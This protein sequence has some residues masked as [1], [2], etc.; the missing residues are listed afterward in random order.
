LAFSADGRTLATGGGEA[1]THFRDLDEYRFSAA[2]RLSDYAVCLWDVATGKQVRRLEGHQGGVFALGFSRDG[3]A[4]LSRSWDT[5]A[6]VWGLAAAGGQPAPAHDPLTTEELQDLWAGL[7]DADAEKAHRAVAKLGAAPEQAVPFLGE[8]LRPVPPVGPA[9]LAELLANL[10]SDDFALRERGTR[11]LKRLAELAEEAV[12]KAL[13]A[14]PSPEMRRRLE[15]IVANL[16][17]PLPPPE[18]LQTLRAL[19]VLEQIGTPAARQVLERLSRGAPQAWLTR[20]A[21]AGV[22]RLA[23]KPTD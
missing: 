23:R 7:R 1:L 18:R 17:S 20:E 16:E 3:R 11:E 19:E 5:T 10:D 9:R 4:L 13:Q 15:D 22:Q 8:R 2:A 14:Q 21:E 12:R 6:L